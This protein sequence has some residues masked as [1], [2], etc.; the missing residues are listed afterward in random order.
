MMVAAAGVMVLALTPP[1][2]SYIDMPAEGLT[3]PRLLLEFRSVAVYEVERVD[4]ERGAVKYKMIER[5][6]GGANAAEVRHAL[7]YGEGVPG[8]LKTLKPGQRAVLFAGDGYGRGVTLVE[9]AWYCSNHDPRGGW[10]NI[11]YTA[12]HYDFNCAYAGSVAALVPAIQK[13]LRGDDVVV[14]CR[15]KS[16]APELQWIRSSLREPHKKPVVEAPKNTRLTDSAAK[17]DFAERTPVDRLVAALD[18]PHVSARVG[19]ALALGRLGGEGK[20]AVPALIGALAKDKD[21]FVRRAAAVALGEIGPDATAAVPTLIGVLQGHY[22]NVEG[23]VGAEA[24][25][26]VSRV[27]P[28]GK[29]SVALLAPKLRDAS[30]DVRMQTASALAILGEVVKDAA[31]AL[32]GALKDSIADVRYAVAVALGS[33]RP[34]PAVAVPALIEALQDKHM[35]V[36]S[37]AARSL[38]NFG[39]AAKAALPALEA[40]LKDPDADVRQTAGDALRRIRGE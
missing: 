18:N 2:Q 24:S 26:A 15:K 3:I 22:E 33:I 37:V 7:K 4:I 27:D 12:G 28:Q 40:R 16:R 5:L 25:L 19:A 39:P 11:A 32:C 38:G 10:W 31:P 21:P 35:Y 23:L 20:S 14:Q 34:D 8:E 36:R 30:P 9:G 13:L 29:A 1:A 6:Q 17:D